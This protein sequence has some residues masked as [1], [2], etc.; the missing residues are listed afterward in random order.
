MSSSSSSSLR[1]S[2][3]HSRRVLREKEQIKFE[4]KAMDSNRRNYLSFAEEMDEIFIQ[5]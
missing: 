3:L 4:K 1:L 2:Q 5:H